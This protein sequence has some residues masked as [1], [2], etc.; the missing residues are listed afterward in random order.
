MTQHDPPAC[1]V[2]VRIISLQTTLWEHA[3]N[4]ENKA[5]DD[6][7]PNKNNKNKNNHTTI[8]SSLPNQRLGFFLG[9][10]HSSFVMGGHLTKQYTI[11]I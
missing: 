1:Q 3:R 4:P 2:P 6:F 10:G 7:T 8:N 11:F 5:S 9:L